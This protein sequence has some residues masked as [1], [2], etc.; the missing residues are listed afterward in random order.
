MHLYTF[1]ELGNTVL[2]ICTYGTIYILTYTHCI[3]NYTC[4]IDIIGVL[5]ALCWPSKGHEICSV[6]S[7][8]LSAASKH[9]SFEMPQKWGTV[10]RLS[11]GPSNQVWRP[12]D[13][14][15]F[16]FT[17]QWDILPLIKGIRFHLCIV[18]R[19]CCAWL[20]FILKAA[21]MHWCQ[22]NKPSV[23]APCMLCTIGTL[24]QS[25]PYRLLLN[26]LNLLEIQMMLKGHMM[27]WCTP[28]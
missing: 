13:K 24:L 7:S 6:N 21:L 18:E 3:L 11:S 17:V 1:F 23:H 14:E 26:H 15:W 12:D 2:I 19:P 5:S 25:K 27:G 20:G 28:R 10:L 9:S 22:H 8:S 16:V 4:C